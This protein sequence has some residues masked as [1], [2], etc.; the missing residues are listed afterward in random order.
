MVENALLGG[1]DMMFKSVFA[2]APALASAATLVVGSLSA[3]TDAVADGRHYGYWDGHHHYYYYSG[4]YYRGGYRAYP[5]YRREYYGPYVRRYYYYGSYPGY[6]YGYSYPYY[7]DYDYSY[8]YYR[9]YRGYYDD[10]S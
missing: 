2:S 4:G 1:V 8:P 5:G 3:A 6:G 7:R 9:S 10:G